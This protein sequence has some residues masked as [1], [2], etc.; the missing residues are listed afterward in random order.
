MNTEY[1][2]KELLDLL[3]GSG[4]YDLSDFAHEMADSDRRS[5][6]YRESAEFVESLSASE[7]SKAFDLA[8]ELGAIDSSENLSSIKC[9]I[10]F[11]A[12]YQAIQDQLEN[13]GEGEFAEWIS[14]DCLTL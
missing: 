2:N 9:V 4:H 8:K 13:I 14:E 12:L 7:E 11:F 1:T 5:F 10:A 3:R 6:M